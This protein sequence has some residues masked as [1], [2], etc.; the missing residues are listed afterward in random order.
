MYLATVTC[1]RDFQQMLLQAESISK[2]VEPCTHVIIINEDKPDIEFWKSW[3]EPYYRN[4]SLIIIPRIKYNFPTSNL[5]TINKDGSIDSISNGWR[6]QQLQKLLLAYEFDGDY[7]LLD[8]KNFFTKK[9]NI[10][11]WENIIGAGVPFKY[12]QLD[13]LG[14]PTFFTPTC[15]SYNSV[16]E[17]QTDTYLAPETPFKIKKNPLVQQCKRSELGYLLFHPEFTGKIASEFIFYSYFVQDEAKELVNS[18]DYYASKHSIVWA[19]NRLEIGN[20]LINISM[21]PIIKVA[22]FHREILSQINKNELKLINFW[23]ATDTPKFGL[24]LENKIYPMPRDSH[25]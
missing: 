9:T 24:G 19:D 17:I 14:N 21:S 1:N 6:T 5:G 2:F 10:K 22:G 16:L 20:F 11:E 15:D 12:G 23:L 7:L 3:L 18:Y 13:K 25:V 4:H 8:S